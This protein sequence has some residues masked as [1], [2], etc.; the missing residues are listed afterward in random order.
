MA[1]VQALDDV[2]RK[3]WLESLGRFLAD[4]D[5]GAIV[6]CSALKRSHRDFIDTIFVGLH[7]SYELLKERMSQHSGQLH[8]GRPSGL[9]IRDTRGTAAG[10]SGHRAGCQRVPR[11]TCHRGGR[12]LTGLAGASR[13]RSCVGE[14]RFSRHCYLVVFGGGVGL[15]RTK[16]A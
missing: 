5:A 10:G 14:K 15:F 4:Q 12:I 13:L 6:G 9:A 8:A 7:G 2:D 1:S 16:V 3:P 11:G